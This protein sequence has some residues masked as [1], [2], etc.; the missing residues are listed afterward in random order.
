M[1][2][3]NAIR[4]QPKAHRWLSIIILKNTPIEYLTQLL[5]IVYIPECD[6]LR[7]I[8]LILCKLIYNYQV[9]RGKPWFCNLIS[10]RQVARLVTTRHQ[11]DLR[12]TL[13]DILIQEC[14]EHEI[15]VRQCTYII[16]VVLV[17]CSL[18]FFLRAPY[19]LKAWRI[20]LFGKL[21]FHTRNRSVGRQNALPINL[22]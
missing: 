1:D 12:R 7:F 17:L 10:D 18:L 11:A 15:R 9:S 21:D 16:S 8:V 14:R 22:L 19:L 3:S 5:M 13:L 6:S 4:N 20:H 2:F